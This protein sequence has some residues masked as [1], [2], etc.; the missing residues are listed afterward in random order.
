[1]NAE[2]NKKGLTIAEKKRIRELRYLLSGSGKKKEVPT[3]AQKTI[4]F[5]KMYQNG[6]CQVTSTYYTKM[7]EF[8]DV[9]YELLDEEEQLELL[10]TYSEF[11]NFFEPGVKCQL[12]LF[13]LRIFFHTFYISVCLS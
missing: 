11:I 5:Q 9:N 8:F 10:Q 1:M 3:T 6:I 13:F 12:F 2:K 4:P 7:V